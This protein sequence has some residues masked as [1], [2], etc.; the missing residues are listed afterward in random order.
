[1][2]RLYV[3]FKRHYS[4]EKKTPHFSLFRLCFCGQNYF[5]PTGK[6]NSYHIRL[7]QEGRLLCVL[8]YR[9]IFDEYQFTKRGLYKTANKENDFFSCDDDV[10]IFFNTVAVLTKIY[11][12]GSVKRKNQAFTRSL[13]ILSNS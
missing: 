12:N 2:C 13:I 10:T 3:Y 5:S 9:I 6:K 8:K 7:V 11:H 4:Q 1:M